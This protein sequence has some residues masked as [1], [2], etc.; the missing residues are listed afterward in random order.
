M[1]GH[2]NNMCPNGIQPLRGSNNFSAEKLSEKE[3]FVNHGMPI[4]WNFVFF[5]KCDITYP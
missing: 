1:E 4:L 5:N 2:G 3:G